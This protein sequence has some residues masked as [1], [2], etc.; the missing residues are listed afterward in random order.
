MKKSYVLIAIALSSSLSISSTANAALGGTPSISKA[1]LEK[2]WNG[3][4]GPQSTLVAGALLHWTADACG[5]LNGQISDKNKCSPEAE[6]TA[7]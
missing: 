1:H 7:N 3:K 5:K 2:H 4:Q 6:Q